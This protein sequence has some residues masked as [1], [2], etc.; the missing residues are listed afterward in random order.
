MRAAD[1]EDVQSRFMADEVDVIVATTAFGMGIDKPNVRFVLHADVPDS[2]DTYYQ[3]IGRAGRDGQPAEVVLFYRQE[4]FGLRKF[5]ASGAPDEV[6]LRKVM[7]LVSLHMQ[8]E[9]PVSHEDLRGRDGPDRRPADRAGQPAGAG[10][11]AAGDRRGPDRALLG[12]G[13]PGRRPPATR[14]PWPRR[15]ARSSSRASR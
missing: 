12:R 3:E 8:M 9:G 5:F 13:R 6:A 14:S 15:T 11:L 10:R 2:V 1:R 7:T 4:D